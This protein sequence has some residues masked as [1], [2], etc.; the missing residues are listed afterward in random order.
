MI[1]A[2]EDFVGESERVENPDRL[3]ASFAGKVSQL[4]FSQVSYLHF[5]LDPATGRDHICRTTYPEPWV[6]RYREQDYIR[7]DPV[8]AGGMGTTLPLGWDGAK[9]M[10]RLSAKQRRMFEEAGE[11]GLKS[12]VTIP[13]HGVGGEFA[14]VHIGSPLSDAEFEEA[15]SAHRHLIHVMSIYL[16]TGSARHQHCRPRPTERVN[17]SERER[18]CLAWMANGKTNW[19]ISEI[20]DLSEKTVDGYLDNV[21]RKLGVYTK[22][23][24]V[25]KAIMQGLIRP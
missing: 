18:E 9:G 10:S 11:F 16:H 20:L 21:K 7:V 3:F 19:E 25:V 1:G 5:R 8:I 6:A 4:G 22:T 15:W 12:G 17:L 13:V 14:T 24:A 23:Q 2:I